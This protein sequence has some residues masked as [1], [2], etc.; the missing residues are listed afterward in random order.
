MSNRT[1]ENE[2]G[3]AVSFTQLCQSSTRLQAVSKHPENDARQN[4]QQN[5]GDEGKIEA[6]PSPI[7]FNITRNTPVSE[8]PQPWRKRAH[9]EHN[10]YDGK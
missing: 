4:R 3:L 1:K 7:D 6:L 5:R 9:D 10:K 8:P 2:S